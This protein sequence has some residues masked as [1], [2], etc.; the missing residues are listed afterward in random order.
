ML[1]VLD[2][3]LRRHCYHYHCRTNISASL[4]AGVLYCAVVT[5]RDIVEITCSVHIAD[6][7]PFCSW[8][9]SRKP[10][11]AD[12]S[13]PA[14]PRRRDAPPAATERR[15][16]PKPQGADTSPQQDTNRPTPLRVPRRQYI[17]HPKPVTGTLQTLSSSSVVK[18]VTKP[19]TRTGN[20]IAKYQRQ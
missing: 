17:H 11:D 13:P 20:V 2:A 5:C 3:L 6:R 15:C 4:V 9:A 16:A 19:I 10:G 7:F 1:N 18:H 8:R 14:T 12:A